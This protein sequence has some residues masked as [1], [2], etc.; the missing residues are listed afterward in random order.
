MAADITGRCVAISRAAFGRGDLDA[1]IEDLHRLPIDLP[2]RGVLAADLLGALVRADPTTEPHRLRQLD[3]LLEIAE[4]SPPDTPEWP[5]MRAAARVT[6]LLH[7]GM[8]GEMSDPFATLA[9]VESFLAV[10]PTAGD[11]EPA[12]RLW[13]AM[14]TM[15][16]AL[17]AT[18]DGDEAALDRLP[19]QAHQLR[20][21]LAD[22]AA[23]APIADAFAKL[24][25]LMMANHRGDDPAA[26]LEALRETVQ[27][28]PSGDLIR[29]S[30]ME[31]D[32]LMAPLASIRSAG[33]DGPVTRVTPEQLAAMRALVQRPDL[34]PGERAMFHSG[35]GGALLALGEERD[36]LAR[37]EEAVEHLR[38]SVTVAP[39]DDSRLPSHLVGLALGLVHRGEVTGSI[40]DTVEAEEVL[41]R[42][43]KLAGGPG[44]ALW[45]VINE[46]LSQV[47]RH[48]GAENSHTVALEGL[49]EH[50]WRVLLQTD[51]KAASAAARRAVQDA[52]D[53]ARRCLMFHDPAN[54]IRALDSGRGLTLYAA[55][56]N[57]HIP[58]RLEAAGHP[59]LAARWRAVTGSDE[60]PEVPIGLRREVLTVLTE[61]SNAG[62]LLDAPTLGE[63]RAA[64]HTLDADALVYLMPGATPVPGY[65]VIAPVQGPPAYM[66][67]PNLHLLD[68]VDVERYLT[69]LV[70][71]DTVLADPHRD[72][73]ALDDGADFAGSLD[74]VCDWAWRAAIGPLVQR[75]LPNLPRADSGRLPRLV[76]VP[77]GELARIPWQAARRSDGTYA[78][79][80]VAISQTA[81]AR[82]LC[83]SA[84]L[85][86]VAPTPVGLV[87]GD[88]DPGGE[89]PDLTAARLEAYAIHR[90]FY[91]GGRYVGRRADG[92][93]SRS[94]TGSVEEVRAWLTSDSPGAG[95]VLHLAC[96]GVINTDPAVATSY[97]LLAD[98]G[99]LAADELVELTA[100][101]P[102]RA[103][104]LIVLAACRTGLAIN[105]YDEAYSLGTAFLAGGVRSVLSTQWAIPDRATSALMYMFHHHLITE[106]LPAWEALRR[107]QSW[108]LDPE[109]SIPDGMPAPLRRHLAHDELSHVAAWAGF[110]HFGH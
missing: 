89:A 13:N 6:A 95:A 45:S 9:K 92:S 43:K 69:A 105:G 10:A 76:L 99:R 24:V 88:P 107:A 46:L 85:P 32:T 7:A 1:A 64:L 37:V 18:Y 27:R 101:C 38:M 39:P 80:L 50:V 4:G 77:M 62:S 68:D 42:A 71:R 74:T 93:P 49:R 30:V 55:T 12:A 96:H 25:D 29:T 83:H 36:D 5:Q 2:V 35:I 3:D 56:E 33:Q 75:Y 86:P 44:H 66:A 16:G 15:L 70:R 94:G 73:V 51:L 48:V 104:G 103:I 91:P 84:A 22:D 52:I 110:V 61:Q 23:A 53:V 98:G 72:L 81:S 54:A 59:E 97:L 57:R 40:A 100:R 82:M 60:A 90:S 63:I 19:G 78:V 21:A 106:G 26:A 17:R 109:R 34:A 47:R 41:K 108:M 79:R 11:D 14:R 58:S 67:L 20:D 65:A 8:K 102:E 87:V 28:L 31:I